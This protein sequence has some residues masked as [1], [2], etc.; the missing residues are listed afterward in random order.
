M[1]QAEW[2]AATPVIR[3]VH[4][5]IRRGEC[6]LFLGA[7]V[8]VDSG[9]PSGDELGH[10]LVE[11]FL[12]P[13]HEGYA[14]D[15]ICQIIEANFGR[16]ALNDWLTKRF[17]G[18]TPGKPL[19]QI[20]AFRWKS[21]F[22]V[23]FDTLLEEAYATNVDSRQNLRAFYSDEDS[24]DSLRKDVV[25]LYKLHGCLSRA[26]ELN[27]APVLTKRDYARA[28][29]SRRN[30]YHRLFDDGSDLTIL[31]IGFS[32]RDPDFYQV[33]VDIADSAGEIAEVPWS[34]AV[35]PEFDEYEFTRW[36]QERVTLIKATATEFFEV[37][38][39]GQTSV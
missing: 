24:T 1:K 31:Y 13:E 10:E 11:T 28:Q 33:L 27:G 7:G 20:P 5:L 35:Q 12:H 22:T 36:H 34:Y 6:V 9:A 2:H 39:E 4:D 14:L 26:G 38:G 23:N 21:I 15:E 30:L 17:D 37:V 32:R 25:P 19:T 8:S 18:L 16:Q 3:R 29:K